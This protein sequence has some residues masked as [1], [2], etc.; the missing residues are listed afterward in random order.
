MV[1]FTV[2]DTIKMW[3]I[4]MQSFVNISSELVIGIV[5]PV[6]TNSSDIIQCIQDC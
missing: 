2:S 6:G 5:Q 4:E 1:Q 3:G